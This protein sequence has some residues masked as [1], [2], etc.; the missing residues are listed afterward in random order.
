MTETPKNNPIKMICVFCGASPGRDPEYVEQAKELGLEMVR[1]GYGLVYG[2]GSYGLMG[3]LAQTVHQNGGRVV[4]IIPEALKKVERPEL[5]GKSLEQVFGEEIVV[6][7]MHTRKGLMNKMSDAFCALPGGYGTFEELLEVTTWSQL[8]IHTKPVMVFNMK[9]Y[10][11]HL[12]KF[13]QHGIDEKF[14]VDWSANV[15]VPG[16]TAK[17]VLDKMEVYEPPKSRFAL[18]WTASLDKPKESFV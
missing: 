13:I 2:G 14:I 10:Y 12:L 15:M 6:P 1:R 4:G 18:D 3:T 11:D 17:E 5:D 16:T 8:S 7:D 9:G